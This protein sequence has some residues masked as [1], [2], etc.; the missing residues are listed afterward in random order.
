MFRGAAPAAGTLSGPGGLPPPDRPRSGDG[1]RSGAVAAAVG[2]GSTSPAGLG[3]PGLTDAGLSWAERRGPATAGAP[4]RLGDA[5]LVALGPAGAPDR[6]GDAELVALGIGHRDPAL[7]PLAGAVQERGSRGR[8][9]RLLRLDLALP[10][11]HI[12]MDPV[13]RR[14]GLGHQLEVDPPADPA[15]RAAR[16]PDG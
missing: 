15:A 16:V 2:P 14:L 12:Q 7:R 6:L 10:G 4:D 5:E 3:S 1:A 11:T 8:Q 13:L 9:P